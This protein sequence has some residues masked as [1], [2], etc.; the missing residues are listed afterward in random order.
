[1]RNLKKEVSEWREQNRRKGASRKHQSDI[2]ALRY[3]RIQH[4]LNHLFNKDKNQ[5]DAIPDNQS[6]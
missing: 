6:R 5:K 2:E 3:K 4:Q 1:M